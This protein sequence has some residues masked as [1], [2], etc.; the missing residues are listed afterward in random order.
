MTAPEPDRRIAHL[1]REARGRAGLTQAA[2]A[3]L[4]GIAQPNVSAYES[5]RR[6]PT[7]RT[8]LALL[9]ACGVELVARPSAVTR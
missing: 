2:L 7:V 6:S 3:D 8:L 5:G 4:A 1:L 9:D